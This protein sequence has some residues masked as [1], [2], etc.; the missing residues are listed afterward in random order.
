MFYPYS[1][2]SNNKQQLKTTLLLAEMVYYN[3][4]VVQFYLWFNFHFFFV[5]NS[6]YHTLPYPKTK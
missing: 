5:S 1:D 2:L 6:L 3:C 4:V